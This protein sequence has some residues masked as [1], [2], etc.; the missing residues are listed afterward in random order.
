[1]GKHRKP[2]TI[3]AANGRVLKVGSRVQVEVNSISF[4][5]KKT[6]FGEI[7]DISYNAFWEEDGATVQWDDPVFDRWDRGEVYL[8]RELY[9]E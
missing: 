9:P 6:Y 7:S 2:E 1:M 5:E 4:G 3:A 8:E